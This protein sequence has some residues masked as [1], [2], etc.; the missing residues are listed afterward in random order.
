[1]QTLHIPSKVFKSAKQLF[2]ISDYRAS[3]RELSRIYKTDPLVSDIT[4]STSYQQ[5]ITEL[6][7]RKQFFVYY[8]CG[9]DRHLAIYRPKLSKAD[10]LNL[11]AL[12]N[13]C[14]VITPVL[15]FKELISMNR[16]VVDQFVFSNS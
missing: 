9:G 12:K 16:S 13:M 7:L 14:Y 8:T 11:H 4:F 3:V 5:I 6:L 1:M 15:E 10:Y 2:P